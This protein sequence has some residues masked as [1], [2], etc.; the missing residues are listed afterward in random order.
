MIWCF[1]KLQRHNIRNEGFLDIELYR[2]RLLALEQDFR[3]RIGREVVNAR[4][5]GDTQPDPG[6][7]SVVEE[8]RDASF[9]LVDTDS[10]VLKEIEAALERIDDGSFGKCSVDG[11]AI[12]EKRLEAVPWTRYCVKHQQQF[13]ESAGMRTPKL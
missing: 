10:G 6:D 1:D 11:G 5:T 4:E 7:R 13:E 8:L 3:E 9:T 2:K 12:E